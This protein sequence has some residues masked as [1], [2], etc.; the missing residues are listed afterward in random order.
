MRVLLPD[1]GTEKTKLE[2]IKNYSPDDQPSCDA[3]KYIPRLYIYQILQT[4]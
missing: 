2:T 4:V 3:D 1:N